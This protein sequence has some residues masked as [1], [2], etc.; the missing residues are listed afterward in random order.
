DLYIVLAADRESAATQAA[1]LQISV[2]PLVNWVWFG[3]GMLAFGTVIA[4]LP[5]R[6]YSFALAKMPESAVTGTA[7]LLLIAL[8][9]SYG[10]ATVSAQEHTTP[11]TS[12]SGDDVRTSYYARNDL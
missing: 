3:F 5:E 2:N 11:P 6:T 7:A 1:S 9:T 10:G 12:V 8:L 4:L